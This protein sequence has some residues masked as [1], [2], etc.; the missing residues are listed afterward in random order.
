MLTLF[1]YWG[2][3]YC[4]M[5]LIFL[6]MICSCFIST[7]SLISSLATK[8]CISS[9]LSSRCLSVYVPCSFLSLSPIIM[10]LWTP[11]CRTIAVFSSIDDVICLFCIFSSIISLIGLTRLCMSLTARSTSCFN[12]AILSFW[13]SMSLS[14]RTIYCS[15]RSF[16][17]FVLSS[18]LVISS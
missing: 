7:I 8:L 3:V 17:R 5:S 11:V 18:F 9:S 10:S 15:S 1:G 2:F 13:M 12:R 14:R 16:S 6:L 4:L